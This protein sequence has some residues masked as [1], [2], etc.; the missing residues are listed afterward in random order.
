MSINDLPQG[1]SFRATTGPSSFKRKLSSLSK[2]GTLK[3]LN[4]NTDSIV[5]ALKK[6]GRAIR[7]GQFNR[8]RQRAAMKM[9]KENDKNL[10]TIDKRNIKKIFKH[11]AQEPK[12]KVAVNKAKR[13]DFDVNNK[14][15]KIS[16]YQQTKRKILELQKDGRTI[17]PAIN[18]RQEIINNKKIK[19]SYK[20]IDRGFAMDGSPGLGSGMGS[21]DRSPGPPISFR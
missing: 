18:R 9:I 4:D 17:N 1:S 2:Y 7:L 12:K 16:D 13:E 21:S 10:T 19:A 11:L 5:K 20:K 14:K 8:Y 6:Y 3:S 15:Y